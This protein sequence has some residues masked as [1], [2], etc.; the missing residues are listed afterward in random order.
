M[1]ANYIASVP[2]LKGRENYDE[3]SFAAENLLVL[4]GMDNYIKPTAGFEVKPAED[5]KTKAKLILTVDP[6]LY[7]HIKNTKSA[8]ELWTTLKTMFD[9][10]GFSRKITLLRHLISIRLDNCDS[11]ATYVTQMVETAQRLN[12]TGFTIT[13]EWVGSLLLAGL[14]DRYSPMIMAIEHSGIS[15][16]ADVIKSKLLDMEVTRDNDAGAA[17]AAR[18]N[19]SFNKSKKGGPGPSTSVSNKKITAAMTDSSKTITCYKC[20]EDGHYRN[21]CPLL[22]K[23][24][25]KCVFNVV[26]L[27]GKFN[28]TEWYVDSGASAHMTANESWVKN[29]NR[30]PCLPEIVV[31]NEST[32]PI[33][34][35]GDVD[36]VS[37]LKYEI[38]VKDVLCVP[39][40]TTNLLSVSELIKN[41]NNVIFDEK[42]CYIRD[43]NDVLIAT[44]D[45]SDGVYK[46]RLETQHC[47]LAAPAVS[48][49]LWHRRL[50][51]LNSQD[52]KKMRNIV[53]GLSYEQNFDITKSQ[54]TTCCEGKQ[55]R[56]PFSHVGERST[57]LL[58]RVHTDI[59][60]PMETRSLNGARYFILFVDDFSRMTFI[61]F[62]KNKSETLS[63][64]KEFQ[65]LVENQLNKKIKM[66]RSDNGLEFCNKE[67]DN[68]L[69]Q[70]GIIHQRSNNYTP[71]QNGLCER[72]NRTVVEK[73]RC[74]LYDAMVDKRFWAEAAN[75]AVYLK[76]RSVASG[77][78]TTPYEL[79][80]GKKPD[81]SHIRLFGSKVMVHIPK[82]RRLKWD[83]KAMEHILVGYSE[84]VKGYRLYN[85]AKKSLVI[86]RDV[87][88]MENES[89]LKETGNES[90]WIPNEE[91]LADNIEKESTVS[92]GDELPHVLETEDCP[93]D[94]SSVY[95]DGNET[96]TEP[97][98]PATDILDTEV[99]MT[100]TPE[101]TPVVPEKRSRK[102]PERY[103]WYGTCLS[104][105]VSAS[106]EIVFSEALEGPEREQ[107]KRA[108][109]DELQSFEDSDAWELVDNPG[110]VTI[111][112]CRWVFNKK[113]DVDNNVRF[114]A[115]LVAKGFSQKPGID[116]TDTFS[117]VVRHSTLRLLFALSVKMN[118]S[119][120]HLDVTTA[121][122]NGFL[123]ETIYMS[124]PEGF[125]NKSGGKVLKL[126]RAIYG[127]KQSS[128]A[129]YDRVKDLLCKLDFKNSLYEPCL[130]TKT[131]GEV[132]IIVA[133]YVDDFLIFSNCPVE[134]KKLKD[135][136]GS[137]FKLKDLGPVRQYLGMRINVSKN[138][139]TV[140][141]QQYI[142][143]LLTRFNM[144]DCKMHK[145]PIE[146]KLN[147]EKPDKCVPDVPY[148]KLIGSLMYLAV[149][150]RPDISYSV[151]YLSQFN[152]CY[153]N[154]HW[155][156]AKRIL[157]YLQCTKTYCLKYF[158]DGSKLEGF[159]DSDW[160]SDA[161]DRKSYTGFC[162]TMSGSV[163]SWQSRK[164]TSVS[165][166]STE[167]EYTALSEA[168]REGVYLRNL[169]HEITGN[170]SV[171]QIYC[172]NQSALK[173]SLSNQSHNR[174]KHIDVRFHYVRDVVKNKYIKVMY[175]C[176]E[177]MP[178][179][180]LTK[181]L[182]T[183]KH[184]KFMCKLGIV[185]K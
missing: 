49:N 48:G 83:K 177:E 16:T 44:A 35:S 55:A 51:H 90:I 29:M 74:L 163:I 108:M 80:Y 112:R 127:L 184:Y 38:I 165:L 75:T 124:L 170:L 82:E 146:C 62:I 164:Q 152:S 174:S 11:M 151:S 143:Q 34:C 156:Y 107:W 119:I 162:F 153:D 41:G 122:L 33:V 158:K 65:T 105:T 121:F 2:K 86:S 125:V 104:S 106:E 67:F 46:L 21:Q 183:I 69:K 94:S 56:L 133:L 43:K 47:M 50:A 61:Y 4:E 81:L 145:T 159:V 30:S 23:N 71:E 109:A 9:D 142:D 18:N 118:M 154:T 8:A 97:S 40:L 3:W 160:A 32:V 110:D 36:I 103:G 59:C 79:W 26:F 131:K 169:L 150:T 10:S 115:R 92:V 76:N 171:I 45:L 37:E 117:P 39:S 15:I 137:E 181:G 175:L 100:S 7:V 25:S 22:K 95:E 77:L 114:R 31:A 84:E 155:H 66:I 168:A 12:G 141:Q 116:Y 130:F 88:V 14:S 166:S 24:N 57:E 138:V 101:Q 176:S 63:K 91:A 85:L 128:L 70:K 52:M 113:F 172:D 180:L 73:A 132:K 42:H 96:L 147:L 78:Q 28:K 64:F 140:D 182:C 179:D 5:A 98:S 89:E 135:T 148:Q 13:D 161:I 72:A 99:Q 129:W 136:L 17:F 134:S 1:T 139:I 102:A 173:L 126:K 111:V 68:Y 27:N 53:D 20:K 178:A 185:P 120:D 58:Q 19:H 93:S 123:K 60:G 144:L 54:C 167:A 149:L 157:K 87:I 6:S